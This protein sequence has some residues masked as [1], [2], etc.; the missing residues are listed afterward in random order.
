MVCRTSSVNL[1]GGPF[2]NDFVIGL[3]E[4]HLVST[5]SKV[6]ILSNHFK[7]WVWLNQGDPKSVVYTLRKSDV[8]PFTMF[9]KFG[10]SQGRGDPIKPVIMPKRYA[11][12]AADLPGRRCTEK[13]LDLLVDR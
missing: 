4:H 5:M 13:I 12:A 1:V 8:P 11:S 3:G 9:E 7:A 10:V 2:P 6:Q